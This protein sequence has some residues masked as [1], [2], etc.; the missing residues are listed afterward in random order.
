MVIA[1]VIAK[2]PPLLTFPYLTRVLGPELY[3][4]YGYAKNV[5]YL[6][7]LLASIGLVPYGIR[8]VAQNAGQEKAI[9]SKI[10]GIRLVFTIAAMAILLLYTFTVSPA[11]DLIRMLLLIS[12]LIM[13]PS[14]LNLDWLLIG[15][16]QITPVAVAIIVGQML[17]AALVIL[18]VKSK[19]TV[20]VIPASTLAGETVTVS[21]IYYVV[22]KRFGLAW[23]SFTKSD[24]LEIVPVSLLLGFA[25]IVSMSYDK[26]DTIILGYFRPIAEVGVYMAT[27]KIIWMIMSFLPILSTVFFPMVAESV[28]SAQDSVRNSQLYLKIFTFLAFPLITGGVVLAEP[29]TRFII[30]NDYPGAG[31]LFSILLPNLLAGGLANYYAGIKLVALNKNKEYAIAVATGAAANLMLNLIFVPYWGA[32]AAA[33]VTCLSQFSVAGVAAW[34]GRKQESPPLWQNVLKPLAISIVMVTILG[35]VIAFYP[36]AHVLLLVL[37]GC[38]TYFSLW[39]V[40]LGLL[41]SN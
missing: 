24:F 40:N 34:F 29:F 2:L 37:I 36:E 19:S 12:G 33:V 35:S 4:K 41:N 27:Y 39:K 9:N 22:W 3:G 38:T 28:G 16:S 5:A 31:L 7:T 20:W 8:A 21:I 17:Y 23:P 10:I 14:A 11:D 15:R 26:I 25:S 32:I 6:L 30:G 1:D 18:F 13:I